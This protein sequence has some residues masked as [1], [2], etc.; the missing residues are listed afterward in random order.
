MAGGTGFV[1][2]LRIFWQS[3]CGVFSKQIAGQDQHNYPGQRCHKKR[4]SSS[5]GTPRKG[6]NYVE[7]HKTE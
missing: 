3:V 4:Y 7:Q 5:H 1:S 6:L 2:A